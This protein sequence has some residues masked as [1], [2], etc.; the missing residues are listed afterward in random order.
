MDYFRQAAI[1]FQKTGRYTHL[2]PNPNPYSEYLGY[3]YKPETLNYLNFKTIYLK[4]KN[5]D[6]ILFPSWFRHGSEDINQTKERIVMSFNTG[7]KM[8]L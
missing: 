7:Y 8:N 2:Y 1:A 5:G 3:F 6:L 4:P